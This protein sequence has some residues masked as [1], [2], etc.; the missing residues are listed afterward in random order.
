MKKLF[1]TLIT[2]LVITL[3]PTLAGQSLAHGYSYG[4]SANYSRPTYNSNTVSYPV[5]HKTTLGNDRYTYKRRLQVERGSKAIVYN[6]NNSGVRGGS[7]K[8][9]WVYQSYKDEYEC[10]KEYVEPN[11]QLHSGNHLTCGYGYE[12]VGNGRF[13]RRIKVPGNAHLVKEGNAWSCNP[14]YVRNYYGSG[15]KRETR[16]DYYRPTTYPTYQSAPVRTQPVQHYSVPA[17][18]QQTLNPYYVYCVNYYGNN[19]QVNCS[20]LPMYLSQ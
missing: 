18:P 6:Y 13:C 10:K 16:A 12:M 15:C 1:Y 19:P 2:T 11:P 9:K 4:H 20:L 14:G 7:W 8:C 5:S 3:S 17:A